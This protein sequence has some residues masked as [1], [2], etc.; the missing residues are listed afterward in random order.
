MP[1]RRLRGLVLVSVD[2][3]SRSLGTVWKYMKV[4]TL[5]LM[6]RQGKKPRTLLRVD[7]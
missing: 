7:G 4:E 5:S 6:V 2:L 1:K 3:L